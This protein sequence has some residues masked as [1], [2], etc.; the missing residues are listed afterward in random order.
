[1]NTYIRNP[2]NIPYSRTSKRE[3]NIK[4]ERG[5]REREREKSGEEGLLTL[6]FRVFAFIG[7]TLNDWSL[8]KEF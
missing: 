2:R 4:R 6:S 3:R 8:L 7:G 5:G 1:M